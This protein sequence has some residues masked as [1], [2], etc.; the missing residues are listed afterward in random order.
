M[1]SS[2][3]RG[4]EQVHALRRRVPAGDERRSAR[5]SGSTQ[6]TRAE[7]DSPTPPEQVLQPAGRAPGP[8]RARRRSSSCSPIAAVGHALASSVRRRRRDIAVL[9]AIGIDARPGA[10]HGRVAGDD[11]R[12][13]RLRV[14]RAARRAARTRHLAQR[15]PTRRRSKYVPPVALVVVLLWSARLAIVLG[16][17]AGRAARRRR[18][19]RLRAADVLR[20][21]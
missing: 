10:A 16:E 18:A 17:H 13:R 11:A 14:R 7:F 4:T 2:R 3:T 9:R 5:P 19:A 21:E 20:T 8:A 12:A 6:A 15:S 1:P